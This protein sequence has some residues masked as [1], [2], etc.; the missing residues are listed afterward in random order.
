M[1]NYAMLWP[2]HSV[3][4]DTFQSTVKLKL[5]INATKSKQAL[6]LEQC[7]TGVLVPMCRLCLSGL[8]MSC[9]LNPCQLSDVPESCISCQVMLFDAWAG[10]AVR[11]STANC[12]VDCDDRI[13]GSLITISH[14]KIDIRPGLT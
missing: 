5:T 9:E 11:A 4:L 1:S 3:R 10:Q 2:M 14:G 7:L 13:H 6:I 12:G 8:R